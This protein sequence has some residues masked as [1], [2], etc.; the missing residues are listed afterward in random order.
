MTARVLA[1]RRDVKWAAALV[2]PT[3]VSKEY[4]LVYQMVGEKATYLGAKM[5]D[6]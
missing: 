4:I 6:V 3:E 2:E 5:V 1:E